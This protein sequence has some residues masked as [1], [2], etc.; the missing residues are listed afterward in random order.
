MED[1]VAGLQ[2]D[3]AT[4]LNACVECCDRHADANRT[5]L[6]WV[7]ADGRIEGFT[8][9][10]LRDMAARVA[11]MLV[12]QGIGPGYVV[13]GLLPRTPELVATILG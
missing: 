13:A 7:A 3:L 8:F 6:R 11:G 10:E 5:A 2:G 1:A 4:G 9:D 12:A